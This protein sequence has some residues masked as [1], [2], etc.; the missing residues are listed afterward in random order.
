MTEAFSIAP[1]S[2]KSLALVAPLLLII[3]CTAGKFPAAM[4]PLGFMGVV[5]I[6]VFVFPIYSSRR[7]RVWTDQKSLWIRGELHGRNIDMSSLKLATAKIVNLNEARELRPRWRTNGM[8]LPGYQ[9]GWFKL[10]DGEK[11]LLFVTDPTA[12]VYIPTGEGY[13]LLM[14]VS[15][16]PRFLASIRKHEQIE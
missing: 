13:S 1:V 2:G 11:A 3:A 5:L 16:P 6:A 15:D 7:V 8:G 9:T 14:S 10:T 12:V 4:V